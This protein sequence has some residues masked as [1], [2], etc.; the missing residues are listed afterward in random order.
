MSLNT[1]IRGVQIKDADISALQLG[2]DSV[3]T[4]KI[5][6]KNVTLA[7]QADMGAEA[8]I[9]VA[10]A[11]LRP[12]SVAVSGDIT[13]TAAGLASIGATKVIDSMIND[14]VAT[15]LAGSGLTATGGV[16]S[17]DAITDNITEDDIIFENESANCNGSNVVFTL[18]ETPIVSSVQVFLNGLLQEEGSGKDYVLSGTTITFVTAPASD[19]LLL[20]HYIAN[21]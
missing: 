10:D 12:V 16:L 15:G 8:H 19:D 7:K 4:E 1:R 18:A 3:E 2:T 20:V 14:D 6:D 21:D 13:I 9:L 5:K 17:A 11:S